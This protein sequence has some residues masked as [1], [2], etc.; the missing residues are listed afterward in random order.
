MDPITIETVGKLFLMICLVIKTIADSPISLLLIERGLMTR[1]L[2]QLNLTPTF[3][4]TLSLKFSNADNGE[5]NYVNHGRIDTVFSFNPITEE[6]IKNIILCL[7]QSSPGIDN[8]P[9][10]LFSSNVDALANI[11]TPICDKS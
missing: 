3:G 10:T 6:E 9:I 4:E 2:L 7:N 1:I 8:I 5:N 11:I